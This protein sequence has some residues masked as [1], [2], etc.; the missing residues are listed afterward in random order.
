[1]EKVKVKV[2]SKRPCVCIDKT[3]FPYRSIVDTDEFDTEI[4]IGICSAIEYNGRRKVTAYYNIEERD[5]KNRPTKILVGYSVKGQPYKG[6][7]SLFNTIYDT[8]PLECTHSLRIDPNIDPFIFKRF[9]SPED[10]I[11]K[12]EI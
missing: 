2:L 11:R 9:M 8:R 5:D 7:E 3:W 6:C 12:E 4:C 1:M 10:Y